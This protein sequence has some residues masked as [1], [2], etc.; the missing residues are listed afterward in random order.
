[1]VGGSLRDIA[2]IL[3]KVALDI[4]NQIKKSNHICGKDSQF[5]L[6]ILKKSSF[7]IINITHT[8]Y[9]FVIIDSQVISVVR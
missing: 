8:A 7:K 1:M 4:K 2:E 5:I 3:L 6:P 9:I